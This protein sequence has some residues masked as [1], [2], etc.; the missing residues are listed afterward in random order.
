VLKLLLASIVFGA[1]PTVLADIYI[2]RIRPVWIRRLQYDEGAIFIFVYA[3][4]SI[5]MIVSW[6]LLLELL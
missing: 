3:V 1:I 2:Y 6:G 5:T 4:V